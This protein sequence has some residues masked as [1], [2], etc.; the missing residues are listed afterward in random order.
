MP[1][2]RYQLLLLAA[3]I[4]GIF[5]PTI[6]SEFCC[7][8]DLAMIR[9]YHHIQS[10]SLKNIFIPGARGGFYYRPIVTLTFF[11]DKSLFGLDPSL[12]HLENVLIHLADAI[13]LYYLTLQIIPREARNSSYVPFVAALCF[14]LHPLNTESVNWVSGRTDLLAGFFV[15]S[16]TL[17]LIRSHISHRKRYLLLSAVA[18]F[19]GMLSKEVAVALF[20]GLLFVSAAAKKAAREDSA[21][22]LNVPKHRMRSGILLTM[23]GAIAVTFFFLF[24]SIALISN[25]SRI[26]MTLL[27]MKTDPGHTL[28]VF[29]RA[30]G[31][32]M[33]KLFVPY[34]LNFAILEADPLYE[35]LAIPLVVLCTYIASRRTFQ[36]AFFMTG[37]FLII[38]AFPIAFGQIA[39]MPYAERYLYLPSAFI[40]TASVLFLDKI[41]PS[42]VIGFGKILAI[43]VL[44]L[45]AFATAQ[46][47]L[48][49]QTNSSLFEDTI[50]KSPDSK[51]A[52][53]IYG[54]LLSDAGDYKKALDQFKKAGS[55]FTLGYD[56]RADLY[57]ADISF[58]QGNLEEAIRMDEAVLKKS[59]GTSS[60]ALENLVRSLEV[61]LRQGKSRQDKR[62]INKKLSEYNLKLFKINH[63]PHILYRLGHIAEKLGE[64]EKALK[65]YQQ[66]LNNLPN[67][68]EYKKYSKTRAVKLIYEIAH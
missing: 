7:V 67:D 1:A 37:V 18:F 62:E 49:W 31:F 66:A 17:F 32:Y 52:R 27:F 8:D 13:L 35:L 3:I 59:H 61:K 5:Y 55:I 38:P 44:T 28:F 21:V 29:L 42:S 6:F 12:M 40:M 10:W 14:G 19:F 54:S 30:F 43:A 58:K 50:K 60:K 26:G 25:T 4:L 16:S 45:M 56:E 51:E 15:L 68:D 34:P 24:R 53:L 39:W 2:R 9:H 64:K 57:I 48:T 11:I 20:P 23:G 36:A 46:R 41:L 47:N 65:F 22:P 33:K 63:N